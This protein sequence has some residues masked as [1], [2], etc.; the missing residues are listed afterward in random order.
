[1]QCW[2]TCR[3]TCLYAS[4]CGPPDVNLHRNDCVCDLCRERYPRLKGK[5]SQQR[6]TGHIDTSEVA[7]TDVA[8]TDV[9][10]NT[11][12]TI[13]AKPPQ[14]DDPPKLSKARRTSPLSTP[15]M[16]PR[17]RSASTG[18]ATAQCIYRV[19]GLMKACMLIVC[20]LHTSA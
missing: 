10:P 1:M 9:A 14:L 8:S 12:P 13:V 17:R 6:P 16:S 7:P 18:A 15:S 19:S 11:L 20:Q 4:D 2:W 3:D 5:F